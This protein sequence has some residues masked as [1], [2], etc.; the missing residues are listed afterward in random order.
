MFARLGIGL[1]VLTIV[2][3]MLIRA[4]LVPD[5]FDTRER[6]EPGPGGPST[7]AGAATTTAAQAAADRQYGRIRHLSPIYVVIY[8]IVLTLVAF[9]GIM[10]L[11]PHWF[12]N[13]LG[14][15]FFM[16]VVS[17]RATCCSP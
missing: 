16:G 2:G 3:C 4:D 5:L 7:T 1:L 14:G 13:L 11:Q 9:D 15:F 6:G 8:A 10:A 17:R 12:S